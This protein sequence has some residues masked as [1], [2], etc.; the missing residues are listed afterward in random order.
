MRVAYRPRLDANRTAA[1]HGV[2]FQNLGSQ[3]PLHFAHRDGPREADEAFELPLV[4]AGPMLR[5][6]RRDSVVRAQIPEVRAHLIHEVGGAANIRSV[7]EYRGLDPPRA[8]RSHERPR[9]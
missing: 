9:R 5:P 2:H 1:A 6:H 3:A 7:H 8:I 4:R